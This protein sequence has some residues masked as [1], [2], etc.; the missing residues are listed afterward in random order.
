MK[1][2]AKC[3]KDCAVITQLRIKDRGRVLWALNLSWWQNSIKY[4]QGIQTNQHVRG[5]LHLHYQSPIKSVVQEH[6]SES[7]KRAKCNYNTGTN[8]GK[9]QEIGWKLSRT[10]D[11]SQNRQW[12]RPSEKPIMVHP[13]K[14]LVIVP[15]GDEK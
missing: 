8:E 1:A 4:C 14:N 5:Q 6:S 15:Y 13:Q 7:M 2:P 3:Q 9:S 12:H 11:S 10:S